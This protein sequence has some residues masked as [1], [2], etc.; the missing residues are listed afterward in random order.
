MTRRRGN[1]P[2]KTTGSRE[3]GKSRSDHHDFPLST[4]LPLSIDFWLLPVS[5][6]ARSALCL[7]S[8]L[9]LSSGVYG[10]NLVTPIEYV[11]ESV[12]ETSRGNNLNLVI[13]DM[14]LLL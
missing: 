4:D 1:Q 10:C 9:A 12:K 14:I 7:R 5:W 2:R 3:T 6:A 13:H 11:F 8:M